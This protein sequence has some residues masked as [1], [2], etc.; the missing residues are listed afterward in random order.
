MWRTRPRSISK[1]PSDVTRFDR[2]CES[3]LCVQSELKVRLAA[4]FGGLP[5]VRTAY[6]A[7]LTRSGAPS[8]AVCVRTEL[9]D[10]RCVRRI[11]A[12]VFAVL[13]IPEPIAILF[14]CEAEEQ[15]LRRVC[16]PFYVGRTE[17]MR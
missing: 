14:I 8:V 6:L 12:D 5:N 17:T 10:D 4:G 2:L 15:Q 11:A 16:T 9:G 1:T 7:R 13:P 3:T